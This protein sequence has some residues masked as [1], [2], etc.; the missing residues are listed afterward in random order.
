LP[1]LLKKKLTMKLLI[2]ER[3]TMSFRAMQCSCWNSE[4]FG[5][6]LSE[7]K[8]RGF[9]NIYTIGWLS[10]REIGRV[11]IENIRDRGKTRNCLS[12]RFWAFGCFFF[13]FKI[14]LSS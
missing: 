5:Q 12:W 14:F 8:F 9:Y 3:F 10:R 2:A 6:V 13:L 11:K 1:K 4:A 7:L